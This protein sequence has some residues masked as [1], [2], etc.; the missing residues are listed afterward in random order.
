M[1]KKIIIG[2]AAYA[3]LFLFMGLYIVYT[4]H[5]G[6]ARLNDLIRLHQ[7]EILREHF[8]I[9]IK[10]VQADLAV[11]N[12]RFSRG[13]ETVA[14]DVWNMEKV[15]DNCFA[16]H[17]TPAVQAE[18][19]L[20][21]NSTQQYLDALSRVLTDRGSA[22]R[23]AGDEAAAFRD[24]EVLIEKVRDMVSLTNARLT[25]KTEVA[26]R[27]IT[28]SRNVLYAILAMGPLFSLGLAI[29]FIRGFTRP[30]GRLLDATRTLRSGNL[31]HRVEGL[32]EEFGELGASFNEMAGSISEQMRRMQETERT[33]EKANLDLKL[34]Q[35]QMV[36]SE[37][38]AALGTLSSGISHELSTP[39]SVILNMTQLVKQDVKNNPALLKDLEV[40]EYE[41]NQAIKVTRSLL[42]FARSTKSSKERVDVGRVLE[43][44]FKILEFQPAAKSVE[45]VKRLAPGLRPILANAGHV[46]QVFLNIILNAIQA[47]PEG[48]T[49]D[50]STR[51]WRSEAAQGVEIVIRDT[52]GGIPREDLEKIYQPF[53]TTKQDGTGLGLAISYGIVQEHQ[54]KIVVES[55][56]GQG[57]TF[58][59]YLPD[60]TSPEAVA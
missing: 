50:V 38:M 2:L 55:E 47:M 20:L 35:E 5:V 37:T 19:D 31:D 7:V 39:L 3:V 1:K 44:I 60:G 10:R 49:L 32:K 52:G 40:L 58:R 18:I 54:G 53:F 28:R 23:L 14:L 51:E 43:D 42:G 4:I 15:I 16:C 29:V 48:G 34:A 25:A 41:A 30:V 46:R 33:L 27:E 57:T 45:L 59:I 11:R 12:S 24:G 22:S 26:L 8:L 56:V 17:H 36:R 13:F 6:T 9:Q 21:R